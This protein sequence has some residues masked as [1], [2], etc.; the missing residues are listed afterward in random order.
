MLLGLLLLFLGLSCIV[1]AAFNL[2]KTGF[3]PMTEDEQQQ[4]NTSMVVMAIAFATIL[5][6]TLMIT[7]AWN[8][9][10]SLGDFTIQQPQRSGGLG[11]LL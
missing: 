6:G 3:Q 1:T 10:G 7:T 2:G 9:L 5:S 11:D 4:Y 8:P